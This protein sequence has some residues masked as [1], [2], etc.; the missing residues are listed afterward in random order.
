MGNK[1]IP[2][3]F[4]NH[5]ES[6]RYRSYE[7]N[8]TWRGNIDSMKDGFW[9]STS[10]T[11]WNAILTTQRILPSNTV[12]VGRRFSESDRS[13]A[14]NKKMVALFDFAT[15]T[16]QQVIRQ[17]ANCWDVIRSYDESSILLQ[18]SRARIQDS[19]IANDACWDGSS[20]IDF[21]CIPWCEVWYPK[22]IPLSWVTGAFEIPLGSCAGE[23]S[24][25]DC[26]LKF[27]N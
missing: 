16:L 5:D 15:P 20:Q 27:V 6:E 21:G 10:M 24:L 23:I 17:W 14:W 2:F 3:Y 18:I 11:G 26:R 8:L 7:Q 4:D 9:H 22:P 13:F 19:M 12:Q 1:L 25:A